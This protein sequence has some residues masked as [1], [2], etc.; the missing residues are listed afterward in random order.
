MHDYANRVKCVLKT[1]DLSQ[2]VSFFCNIWH[3]EQQH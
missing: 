1:S 3:C 2:F